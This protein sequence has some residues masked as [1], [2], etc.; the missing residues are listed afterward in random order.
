MERVTKLDILGNVYDY[1]VSTG[2]D[3]TMI[4]CIDHEIELL[5]KRKSAPKKP[6]ANQIENEAYKVKIA[7]FLYKNADGQ[8]ATNISKYVGISVQKATAL[9]HQLIAERVVFKTA[10]LGKI[11][12]RFH[13]I[14]TVDDED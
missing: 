14:D 3:P 8:T 11:P 4:D 9:L 6:T 7:Q 12:V 10:S 1:L 13:S 5:K 2:A